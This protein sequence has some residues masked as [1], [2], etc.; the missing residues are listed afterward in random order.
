[1]KVWDAMETLDTFVDDSDPD[2]ELSQLE[3]LLQSAEA[4]RRAGEPDWMVVTALV[5]DLGKVLTL[6]GEPQWA[7][8]GDTFPLGCRFQEA[9]VYH[10]YFEQNPDTQNSEYCT[11]LGIYPG[12]VGLD[13][14]Q[15][16]WG[17][18]EYLFH[19]MRRY[20]PDE[21]LYVI[22]YHSFYGHH[23]DRA[24]DHLLSE[25][26][27]AMLPWL[28]RFNA[29]DLYSKAEEPPD[30]EKLRPYYET[31]LAKFFTGTLAW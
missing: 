4:A 23:V 31:L 7:V 5:H 6:F 25:R 24:Y 13:A 18:D 29:Y 15:M 28:T 3:H 2:T 19:V 20:L 26:D 30:V 1:M 8:V 12:G 27:Y 10:S 21:A 11:D 17:H 16:S 14:V 22:R 9:L